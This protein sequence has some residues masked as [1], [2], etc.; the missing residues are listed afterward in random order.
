MNNTDDRA[1]RRRQA[2]EDATMAI[3]YRKL[4]K[5]CIR[6]M[7]YEWDVPVVPSAIAEDGVATSCTTEELKLFDDLVAEVLAEEGHT[8]QYIIETIAAAKRGRTRVRFERDDDGNFVPVRVG[9]SS[10]QV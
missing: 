3:N 6:G 2:T 1:G 4:L 5:D 7:I 10:S 8:T 9:P